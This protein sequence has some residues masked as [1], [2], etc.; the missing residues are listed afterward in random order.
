MGERDSG[1]DSEGKSLKNAI[2]QPESV[3]IDGPEPSKSV[4]I[5]PQ[6]RVI[7]IDRNA[8]PQSRGGSNKT[9]GKA[10][11]EDVIDPYE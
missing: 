11:Y 1:D 9:S 3:K 2:T 8:P 4:S 6:V 7:T 5:N 10:I